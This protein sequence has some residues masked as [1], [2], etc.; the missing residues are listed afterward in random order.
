MPGYEEVE[1]LGLED[2]DMDELGFFRGF[3]RRAARRRAPARPSAG[4][5]R[6]ALALQRAKAQAEAAGVARATGVPARGV[7]TSSFQI[8]ADVAAGTTTGTGETRPLQ[9]VKPNRISAYAYD[10]TVA[11]ATGEDLITS[12]IIGTQSLFLGSGAIPV[13]MLAPDAQNAA[14]MRPDPIRS[15]TPVTLNV[16]RTVDPAT[17]ATRRTVMIIFGETIS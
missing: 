12:V 13:A 3:K 10:V 8:V 9:G 14:Q 15:Q 16:S 6:R 11:S 17:T 2:D 5:A 7:V 1:L 4:L